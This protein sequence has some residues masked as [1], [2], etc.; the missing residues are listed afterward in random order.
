MNS[1]HCYE[2]QFCLTFCISHCGLCF[3]PYMNIAKHTCRNVSH[4]YQT[5]T[6]TSVHTRTHTLH[7]HTHT[8]T[9]RHTHT[10]MY[11]YTDHHT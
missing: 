9:H 2:L 3:L 4:E 5:H 1:Q 7:T 8:H 10:H 6:H 11:I